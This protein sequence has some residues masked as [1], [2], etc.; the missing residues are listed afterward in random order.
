MILNYSITKM[1]HLLQ[2]SWILLLLMIFVNATQ[3]TVFENTYKELE[4]EQ[5]I[6][7]T[8]EA[9][10]STQTNVKWSIM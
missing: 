10:L 2:L 8:T 5:N 7:G 6:T 9:E 4:M 1:E 3:A